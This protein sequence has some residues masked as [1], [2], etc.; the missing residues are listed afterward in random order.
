MAATNLLHGHVQLLHETYL[1]HNEKNSLGFS[2][3]TGQEFDLSSSLSDFT[4]VLEYSQKPANMF[5]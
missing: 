2:S 1:F 3:G 5:H 4:E